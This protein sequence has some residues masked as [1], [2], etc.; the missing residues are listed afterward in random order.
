MHETYIY[1]TCDAVKFFS[2]TANKS[3]LLINKLTYKYKIN[4]NVNCKTNKTID[5]TFD[6]I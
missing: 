4:I 1:K 5:F 6:V 2:L 3:F